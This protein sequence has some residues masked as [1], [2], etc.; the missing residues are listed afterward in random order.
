MKLT[1]RKW[2][3][4]LVYFLL[5]VIAFWPPYAEVAYDSRDTQKVIFEILQR[6]SAPYAAWGWVFHVLTLAVIG[7]ALWKPALGGRA[8]AVYF[9]L[10]YFV[11]AAVQTRAQTP[12]YGYAVHTGALVAEI[13]LGL[14]W[15][16]VAWRGGLT[17]SFRDAP[18]W[19]WILLPFALLVF[20]SPVASE[21]G[22]IVFDFNPLL[23]LTSPDYGLAYCFLTPVFLFLLILAW[24]QVDGFAFRVTAF[25]GLLYGLFNLSAWSSPDTL[26]VGV[27]HLPLLVIP[28]AAL[29]LAR[30]KPQT[31]P[32][33]A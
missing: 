33:P 2:F 7:L 19:R 10:N 11:I 9:G 27:M 31:S 8:A 25:N 21:G 22:R 20:W 12:T 6:A 30:S 14:L 1:E 5:V 16:W 13:L 24:P 18:R 4:P 32:S 3:Y 17:L 29:W 15:L 23:L 28:I 26:V